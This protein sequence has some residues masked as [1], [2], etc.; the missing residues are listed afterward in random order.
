MRGV[1]ERAEAQRIH[2]RDRAGAHRED[3][4]DDAA[5]AGRRT[6]VRL[7]RR[8]VVVALD[9]DRDRE[10]VA[11]VDDTGALTRAD[12][13]PRRLGRE[14]A[15]MHARRL[16]RAVLG[17]HHG[18]HRELERRSARGRSSATT[19]SSSSSVIP[20]C[21][22]SGSGDERHRRDRPR[23]AWP[24]RCSDDMREDAVDPFIPRN[25]RG[26]T[27]AREDE[28]ACDDRRAQDRAR[29]RPQSREDRRPLSRST[30]SEQAEAGPQAH[31]GQREEAPGSGRDAS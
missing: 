31:G 15:E 18:V 21:R 8:R 17:P 4:A 14:P 30:R 22:C 19:A 1:V 11:D 27:H 10:T 28:K 24:T 25:S 26:V 7:D 6:L 20:S 3:V 2:Q 16:V 5:D 9:A 29:R 12:E 23:I 13:H